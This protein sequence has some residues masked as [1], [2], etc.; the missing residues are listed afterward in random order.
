[1]VTRAVREQ[2]MQAHTSSPLINWLEDLDMK[3]QKLP[4]ADDWWDYSAFMMERYPHLKPR[5]VPSA[6]N[7]EFSQFV[8]QWEHRI[9]QH[10]KARGALKSL[11]TKQRRQLAALVLDTIV[12]L[13][14]YRELRGISQT[15]QKLKPA[16]PRRNQMLI[17][18]I[19]KAIGALQEVRDYTASAGD[20]LLFGEGVRRATDKCLKGLQEARPFPFGRFEPPG[21]EIV[22]PVGFGMVRLY[23][24][25]RHGCGI[26]GDESEVRVALIRNALWK[27][28]GISEVAYR[29]KYQVGESKGCD[30]VHEA[31]SR[32]RFLPGT[33]RQETA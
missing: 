3:A 23:W 6:E 22:S 32:F 33:T 13:R 24:F 4:R 5:P 9:S 2:N 17:K 21:C 26:S 27:K 31:V 15:A 14:D 11:S 10:P 16:A 18:K 29:P 7:K 1:M 8:S 19:N 30:A 12:E 28:Y 20:E 25:F